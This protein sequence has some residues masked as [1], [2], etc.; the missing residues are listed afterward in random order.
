M[1]RTND[2][3]KL[4]T[5]ARNAV[6]L[7]M[8]GAAGFLAPNASAYFNPCMPLHEQC[9]DWGYSGCC[10]GSCVCNHVGCNCSCC[11]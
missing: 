4:D 5:V 8:L 10:G 11:G 9:W 3:R 1:R 2:K 7:G 6:M